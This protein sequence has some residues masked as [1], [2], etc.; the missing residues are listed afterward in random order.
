MQCK[1]LIDA[2]RVH[3]LKSKGYETKL[4]TYIDKSVSLENVALVA[5]YKGS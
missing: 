4:V 1:R 3:Y 5:T 2:G